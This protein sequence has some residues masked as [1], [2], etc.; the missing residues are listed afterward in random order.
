MIEEGPYFGSYEHV[1]IMLCKLVHS[2]SQR[3]KL[4]NRKDLRYTMWD[5]ALTCKNCIKKM[6]INKELSK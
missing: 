2:P 5:K 4:P 6:I 3:N 1:R